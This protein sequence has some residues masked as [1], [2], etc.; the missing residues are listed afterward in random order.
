MRSENTTDTF[1]KDKETTLNTLYKWVF[2]DHG[3]V[4]SCV[5]YPCFPCGL[6]IWTTS[7]AV[8]IPIVNPSFAG[9]RTAYTAVN[10]ILYTEIIGAEPN[11][12][13]KWN[14]ADTSS[15]SR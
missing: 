6:H 15:E 14:D 11:W 3:E 5:A 13:R 10:G 9:Q 1:S 8:W 7:Y 12:V 4:K 2:L